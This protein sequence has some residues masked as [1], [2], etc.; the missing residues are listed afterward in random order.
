MNL[1]DEAAEWG[2]LE[3]DLDERIA[4]LEVLRDK[5]A[6]VEADLRSRAEEALDAWE[7]NVTTAVTNLQESFTT[8]W[9]KSEESLNAVSSETVDAV[10]EGATAMCEEWKECVET[11]RAAITG[12]WENG[13]KTVEEKIERLE[14][15]VDQ[16]KEQ[17]GKIE[18]QVSDAGQTLSRLL[19]ATG[20]AVATTG[21]GV[22]SAVGTLKEVRQAF[23][24]LL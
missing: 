9:E 7:E 22:N 20:E 5:L 16:A 4:S 2:K 8:T 23:D 12:L 14:Q 15:R 24:D 17:F 21:V 18:G 6:E 1:Q 13:K 3:T 11:Q 10:V 19:N